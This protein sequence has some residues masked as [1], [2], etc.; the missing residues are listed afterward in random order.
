[1]PASLGVGEP[2]LWMPPAGV[3]DNPKAPEWLPGTAAPGSS[4]ADSGT[5]RY[6]WVVAEPW[7]DSAV[8]LN[9]LAD[10]A[11]QIQD[12]GWLWIRLCPAA[13]GERAGQPRWQWL[14]DLA[15]RQGLE[16]GGQQAIQ[17]AVYLVFRKS[18][19]LVQRWRLRSPVS[20]G[21]KAG[22]YGLFLRA[23]DHAISPELWGWKYAAGRGR[24][25]MAMRGEQVIAHYGCVT[26]RILMR[27]RE[28]RALQICDV[29]VDPS[30]R[31][32]MT[33]TGA[34]F[35]VAKA[36]QEAFIGFGTDH[37]LGYGFPNQR[38]MRLAEKMGL[39]D[40]VERLVELEWSVA[41]DGRSRWTTKPE[42]SDGREMDRFSLAKVWERMS[43][44]M[45]DQILVVRDADYWQYRYVE[46][47]QHDY[48]MLLVRTRLTGRLIGLAVL[49]REAE[50]CKL[51]D[52]LAEPRHMGLLVSH[53]RKQAAAWGASVLKAWVTG[54]CAHWL[55]GPDAVRRATDIVIP[56]NVHA[57]LHRTEDVRGRWFLMMGD[58]DFL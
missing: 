32:I 43:L 40:E 39:Y 33:R 34:F 26:R 58:T 45:K 35:Q 27:G 12:G 18:E 15:L 36:A 48:A 22:C 19:G 38:H 42:L 14:A 28:T 51:L 16:Y 47:P 8:A 55:A 25:T 37:E 21:D 6:S 56:L 9:D 10:L 5:E 53:A 31:A 57:R 23:F 7:P 30:E 11:E 29:M 3:W 1:M 50:E 44:R 46:N 24:A 2:V 20:E 52:V 41:G 17:G 54:N 49:R 4:L 13:T